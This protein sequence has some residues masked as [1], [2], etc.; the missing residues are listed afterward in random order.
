MGQ[1]CHQTSRNYTFLYRKGIE[2]HEL[3]EL[4]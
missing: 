4:N 3:G 1:K 2:N